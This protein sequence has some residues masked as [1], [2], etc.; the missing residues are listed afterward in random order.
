MER[1]AE[2]RVG[3]DQV[4]GARQAAIGDPVDGAVV[5]AEARVAI[6]SIL[7]ALRAHGLIN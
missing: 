4:I 3:G 5:D 1:V 6:R 7:S 2:I